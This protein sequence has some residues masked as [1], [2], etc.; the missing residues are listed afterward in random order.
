MR[1]YSDTLSPKWPHRGRPTASSVVSGSMSI[2][3]VFS[4]QQKDRHTY[5]RRIAFAVYS[6]DCVDKIFLHIRFVRKLAKKRNALM[7]IVFFDRLND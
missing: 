2:T 6:L 5:G 1:I 4:L 3:S 7:S